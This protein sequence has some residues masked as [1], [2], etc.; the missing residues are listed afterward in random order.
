MSR[1]KDLLD[2]IE[3]ITTAIEIHGNEE[4]FFRRSSKATTNE[5]AKALMLEIA[6]D[7]G[8]YRQRLEKRRQLLKD[9]LAGLEAAGR[10]EPPARARQ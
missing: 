4:E 3:I 10:T 6:S 9:E 2:M 8:N 7:I 1:Q 5:P